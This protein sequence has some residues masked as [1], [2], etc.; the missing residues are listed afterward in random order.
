MTLL[1]P[2][3]ADNCARYAADSIAEYLNELVLG[4]PDLIRAKCKILREGSTIHHSICLRFMGWLR[5]R[6]Y[7]TESIS[8]R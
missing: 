3:A 1:F 5:A 7:T 6:R 2:E 8:L 4:L